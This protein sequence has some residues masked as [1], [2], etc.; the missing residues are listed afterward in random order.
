MYSIQH[1]SNS[2]SYE[3]MNYVRDQQQQQQHHHQLIFNNRQ[4]IKTKQYYFWS[5]KL[6]HSRNKTKDILPVYQTLCTFQK[7]HYGEWNNQENTNAI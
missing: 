6:Y 1:S 4:L 7:S 2:S 3:T 5:K